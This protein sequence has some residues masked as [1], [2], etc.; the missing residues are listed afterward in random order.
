MIVVTVVCDMCKR[1]VNSNGY[2][3]VRVCTGEISVRRVNKQSRS[4][5]NGTKHMCSTSC[6]YKTIEGEVNSWAKAEAGAGDVCDSGS[7]K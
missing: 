5:D 4:S 6:L 7:A 1:P 2:F 3:A